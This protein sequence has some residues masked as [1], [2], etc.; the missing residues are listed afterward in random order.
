MFDGAATASARAGAAASLAVKTIVILVLGYAAWQEWRQHI[1]YS[2]EIARE[3]AEK[4]RVETNAL[5]DCA[6]SLLYL[7]QLREARQEGRPL[8]P[9]EPCNP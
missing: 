8:P 3:Q 7:R 4:I 5:K 6:P 9:P 1:I 2:T